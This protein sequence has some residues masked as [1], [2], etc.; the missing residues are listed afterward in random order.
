M[1][2][3]YSIR[4]RLRQ[5]LHHPIPRCGEL[6]TEEIGQ[7]E[8]KE[9]E[10]RGVYLVEVF[11]SKLMTI[12][13]LADSSVLS[14]VKGTALEPGKSNKTSASLP[15]RLCPRRCAPCQK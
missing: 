8:A 11:V 9:E 10:E 13:F 6:E 2:D 3:Q 7:E 1:F 4:I 5:S 12:Y 14:A 15:L